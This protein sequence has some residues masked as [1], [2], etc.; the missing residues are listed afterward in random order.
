MYLNLRCLEDN[1]LYKFSYIIA[2]NPESIFERDLGSGRKAIGSYK[3]SIYSSAK[4]EYK[5]RKDRIYELRVENDP[6][7]LLNTARTLN[8]SNYIHTQLSAVCPHNLK[9][10][11]ECF[12][13]VMRGKN[14]SSTE[15]SQAEFFEANLFKAVLGPFPGNFE[16]LQK[17][18]SSV[19]ISTRLIET[20][21]KDAAFMLELV[22]EKAM[23]LTEFLQKIYLI[24][25]CSTIRYNLSKINEEQISKFVNLCSGWLERSSYKTSIVNTLCRKNKNLIRRFEHGILDLSDLDDSEK[26]DKIKALEETLL[27]KTLHSKRH[28]LIVDLFAKTFGADS[29]GKYIDLG[30]GEGK[31]IK[32]IIEKHHNLDVL[33]IEA[34]SFKAAKLKKHLPKRIPVLNCNVVMPN[35]RDYSFLSVDF[36]TCT[37]VIEH[38]DKE[39]RA[40]LVRIISEF[41]Q[42]KQFVLTTP[43]ISYNKKIEGLEEGELRRRDHKIEYTEPEFLA[44]VVTPLLENYNIE[45]LK[46]DPDEDVQASFVIHGYR[47]TDITNQAIKSKKL[48]ELNSMYSS[49]YL[50]ISNYEVKNKE[51]TAG[52]ASKQMLDNKSIF[53]LAPTIAPVEYSQYDKDFLEHPNECFDYYRERGVLSLYGEKKYMGSRGY[54]L[55]FKDPDTALKAGYDPITINSRQGYP[56]FDDKRK[57]MDIYESVK[58]KLEYDF[59]MLDCEIMPWS[60]KADKLIEKK[61]L[62]PGQCCY[63][64]RAYGNYGSRENAEKYLNAALNYYTKDDPLSIRMFQMLACGNYDPAHHKFVKY[65]NG[66]CIG[67]EANYL[68][69]NALDS[70]IFKTVEFHRVDVLSEASKKESIRQWLDYCANGGEGF[71]YKP[72][73][74]INYLYNGYLIQPALKVR[75]QNYLRLIYG[76]D[77]LDPEYFEKIKKRNVRSKRGL[78]VREFEISIKMVRAFLYRNRKELDKLTA[79]FIGMENNH[80]ASIDATL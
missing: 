47:K 6:L 45:F 48:I 27:K 66:L 30:S 44:E 68:L 76:I 60:L 79:A 1:F 37:E 52:Y 70:D 21:D 26:E 25:Y 18:F 80:V 71:V 64:S 78:A 51:L 2:K 40:K 32:K 36:L 38:L 10:I 39:G 53:Y 69:L 16:M 59:V 41:F 23:S 3:G 75:G 58:D 50:D 7:T 42:P 5:T 56:F 67:R 22:V 4:G 57:L 14:P 65:M 29:T 13:S 72:Q 35:L 62:I 73:Y 24:S 34:D 17:V 11:D 20:L 33:A 63:L 74:P 49:I 15:V 12:R 55:L 43:N 61:F 46:L 9:G 54:V 19:D 28:D 77:Y 31:L 8:M